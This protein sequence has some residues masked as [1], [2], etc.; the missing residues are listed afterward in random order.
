MSFVHGL[1]HSWRRLVFGKLNIVVK[2]L[3][4]LH[5]LS[6]T[7]SSLVW[8]AHRAQKRPPYSF[9]PVTLHNC[10]ESNAH[11]PSHYLPP[12]LLLPHILQSFQHLPY[13]IPTLKRLESYSRQLG[14]TRPSTLSSILCKYSC[15]PI[16]SPILSGAPSSKITSS[17]SKNF[18]P[19]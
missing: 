13:L 5:G 7:P 8:K 4:P 6:S 15:L 12:F 1:K 9:W 16:L 17:T 3:T 2:H 18:L 19:Q 14:P 11:V 10:L